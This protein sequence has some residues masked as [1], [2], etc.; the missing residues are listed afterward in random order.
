MLEPTPAKTRVERWATKAMCRCDLRF[1]SVRQSHGFFFPYPPCHF[2][3]LVPSTKCMD[4]FADKGLGPLG[5]I[6]TCLRHL[7]PPRVCASSTLQALAHKKMAPH[8]PSYVKS[9]HN[10]PSKE[11]SL[12]GG[13]SCRHVR[14]WSKCSLQ[15]A[16]MSFAS[17]RV[18]AP[19]TSN[20]QTSELQDSQQTL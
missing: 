10:L 2:E 9:S 8:W 18:E 20:I 1:R 4:R 12:V 5:S 14:W 11:R 19:N 16:N 3:C 15:T 7:D 13:S 6:W 17:V